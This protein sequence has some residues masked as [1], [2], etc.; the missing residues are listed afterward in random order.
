MKSRIFFFLKVHLALLRL[1]LVLWPVGQWLLGRVTGECLLNDVYVYVYVDVHVHIY[2]YIIHMYVY[3]YVYV[4]VY[5]YKTYI[6]VWG[7][8]IFRDPHSNMQ[9]DG[10]DIMVDPRWDDL[11]AIATQHSRGW[12]SPKT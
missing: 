2:I 1:H 4:Y 7:S 5:V 9:T 6:M 8:P 12:S 11:S 10:H 3:I